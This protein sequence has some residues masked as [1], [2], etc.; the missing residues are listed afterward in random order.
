MRLNFSNLI[1]VYQLRKSERKNRLQQRNRR[2]EI[3]AKELKYILSKKLELTEKLV[4]INNNNHW[5]LPTL[6]I[7][8]SQS[9]V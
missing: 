8:E 6:S 3:A 5:H 4:D 7:C 1:I 2:I 9:N